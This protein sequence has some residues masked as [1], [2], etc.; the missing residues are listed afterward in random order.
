[1]KLSIAAYCLLIEHSPVMIWRADPAK[2]CDYLNGTWLDF[3]GRTAVG[4]NR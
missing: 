3:V 1:M 4:R 2:A